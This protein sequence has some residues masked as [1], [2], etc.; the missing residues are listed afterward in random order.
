MPPNPFYVNRF[1]RIK[2]ISFLVFLIFCSW[3]ARAQESTPS[4]SGIAKAMN[5]DSLQPPELFQFQE[6]IYQ[7]PLHRDSI[8]W[9]VPRMIT[10][11][12]QY[13]ESLPRI[14]ML[15]QICTWY[16]NIYKDNATTLTYIDR[17]LEACEKAGDSVDYYWLT[18]S[19]SFKMF[20]LQKMG[21]EN[22]A[23]T[24]AKQIADR[25][26]EE[27]QVMPKAYGYRQLCVFYE[28]LRDIERS[29][30]YCRKGYRYNEEEGTDFFNN[31]FFETL[32]LTIERKGGQLDSV[33]FYRKKGIQSAKR[34]GNERFLNVG[35]SNLARNYSEQGVQDSAEVYFRLSSDYFH[36]YPYYLGELNMRLKYAQHLNRYGLYSEAS[37]IADTIQKR[38]DSTDYETWI[39]A[40]R[41]K[42][43]SHAFRSQLDSFEFFMAK[44][45]SLIS[46][47]YN[48]DR[49]MA[50]EEMAAKYEAEKKEAAIALLELKN[51]SANLQKFLYLAAVLLL[52][53]TGGFLFWK[54]Q[55][56]TEVAELKRV[57]L[58]DEKKQAELRV[59]QL[60]NDLERSIAQAIDHQK[61]NLELQELV[62]ELNT[63]VE[64]AEVQS[65]TRIIRS[66]MSEYAQEETLDDIE[67]RAREVFP[68]L[69]S[70]LYT[71]LS[72]RSKV[73]L[74]F[75]VMLV[76]NYSNEDI[77]R[78][79]QKS[80]KAI[81]SL[82]Y[83]IRKKLELE[84]G[85]SLTQYLKNQTEWGEDSN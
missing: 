79:L 68:R 8:D 40:Y 5:N 64:N 37:L 36:K 52:L 58:E 57:R 49:A 30:K 75:C 50:Q 28:R 66:R 18:N 39:S 78:I 44:A 7:L 10:R 63:Q 27:E 72:G 55:K 11:S 34:E 9:L 41:V 23:V 13:G 70:K 35:Y 42:V 54:R 51:R 38:L 81:K 43:I 22:E 17:L 60:K 73:E 21:K 45:D 65:K 76:M 71:R 6:A 3:I 47:S 80:D 61:R 69:Y 1:H 12:E 82:R 77:S 32:A 29:L 4:Y 16:D 67:Y 59:R 20:L 25:L 85:K 48:A 74:V 84:E 83:R 53:L 24:I 14:Y 46:V 33:I 19:M 15:Q 56:E 31:S 62:E 26:N 2:E